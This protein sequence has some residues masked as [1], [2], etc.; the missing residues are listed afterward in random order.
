M[1]MMILTRLRFHSRDSF[2]LSYHHSCLRYILR[3]IIRIIMMMEA[4]TQIFSNFIKK[5]F[6]WFT[7]KI[8][9]PM[10]SVFW[11]SSR[12]HF[13]IFPIF[14]SE[15]RWFNGRSR[16]VHIGAS[17]RQTSRSLYRRFDVTKSNVPLPPLVQIRG[18]NNAGIENP[19]FT[20]MSSTLRE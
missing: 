13:N 2:W 18:L 16:S 15:W 1:M 6:D 5:Y 10:L 8:L 14:D 4:F 9:S 17:H 7:I 19:Y 11:I 3:T 12:S 20:V